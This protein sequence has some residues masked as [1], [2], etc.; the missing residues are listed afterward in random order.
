MTNNDKLLASIRHLDAMSKAAFRAA[1]RL[2]HNNGKPVVRIVY[3]P[4]TSK[5]LKKRVM[6]FVGQNEVVGVMLKAKFNKHGGI[7]LLVADRAH[8]EVGKPG[9]AVYTHMTIDR[10]SNVVLLES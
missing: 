4:K 2:L 1:G 5:R 10:V 7:T 6:P 9:K 3:S 8:E